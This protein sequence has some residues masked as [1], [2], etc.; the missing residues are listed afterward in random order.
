M[1]LYCGKVPRGHQSPPTWRGGGRSS[2]SPSSVAQ[3]GTLLV[4][5]GKLWQS[6]AGR[7]WGPGPLPGDEGRGD[8]PL[9]SAAGGTCPFAALR[10]KC[11]GRRFSTSQ[12]GGRPRRFP[13]TPEPFRHSQSS[14]VGK[15][16]SVSLTRQPG[17]AWRGEDWDLKP[18]LRL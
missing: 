4:G 5:L 7:L 16:G 8:Q 18:Q 9:C 12:T 11:T 13:Q 17:T 2:Q 14:P 1:I 15:K 10:G 3:V 6:R